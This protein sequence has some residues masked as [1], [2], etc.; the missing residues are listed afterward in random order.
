MLDWVVP[1]EIFKESELFL[2]RNIRCGTGKTASATF[3][4]LTDATD[5]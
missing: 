5:F 2:F 3:L 4:N 1:S